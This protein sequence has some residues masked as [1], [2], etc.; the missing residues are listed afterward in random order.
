MRS[1]RPSDRKSKRGHLLV[2]GLALLALPLLA[3]SLWPKGGQYSGLTPLTCR[4]GR[5]ELLHEVSVRGTL[6]S[7]ANVEVC[8]EVASYQSRSV[9]ILEVIEEG[10]YVK[11]GD[12]LIELDA[13]GLEE[14]RQQQRI[15]VNQSEAAVVAA[16]T[17]YENAVAA[18]QEYL[19]G[20]YA[21]L[22]QAADID[23]M[24][25]EEKVRK[26]KRYLE[27]SEELANQGYIT[28]AQLQADE[29]ALK[30]AEYVL[31]SARVRLDVLE[32]LTRKR[33]LKTLDSA[34]VMAE[35]R[36]ETQE[37]ILALTLKRLADIEDRIAKCIIRAP[38]AGQVVL[39][40]LNHG[41]HWHWVKPGETTMEGRCLIRLPDPQ[42]MQVTARIPED[43]IGLVRNGLPVKIHCDAFPGVELHGQVQRVSPFPEPLEW[44]GSQAREYETIVSIEQSPITLKPGLTANLRV[45]VEQLS[46]QLLVPCQAV[47]KHGTQN[48]CITFNEQGWQ[49]HEVKLG[50]SNSKYVAIQ[51]GL[52]EG[53]EVVL[54]AAAYRDKVA[55][56]EL[57]DEMLAAAW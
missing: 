13:T 45:L 11:P 38:S 18:Q 10:T 51:S 5:G 40:H 30:S 1:P 7:A 55:L 34:V 49:A 52:E 28:A 22:K 9:R 6:E 53:R 14:D 27:Y 41:D 4:V 15:R 54:N 50:A 37:N 12:V 2:A 24:V 25:A 44:F 19:K 29:F 32:N 21:L 23:L 43:K 46:D 17:A 20:E 36:L 57:T 56:P 42:R 39:A 33:R 31:E 3:G 26:A 35:A 16:R 48:Y 8:C 47:V